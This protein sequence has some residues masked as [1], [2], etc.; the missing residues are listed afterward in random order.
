MNL[1][2]SIETLNHAQTISV[3]AKKVLHLKKPIRIQTERSGASLNKQSELI[4][5]VL[6]LLPVIWNYQDDLID[7][8]FSC[9]FLRYK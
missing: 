2:T 5:G 9:L 1:D 7:R 6:T 4:I 3:A 8:T